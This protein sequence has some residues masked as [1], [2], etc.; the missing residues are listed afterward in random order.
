M[1]SSENKDESRLMTMM[2]YEK[3]QRDV[4]AS[5]QTLS[6]TPCAL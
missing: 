6:G 1:L 5:H 4:N 3:K 2:N